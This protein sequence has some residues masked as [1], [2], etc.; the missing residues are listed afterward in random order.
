MEHLSDGM[1][2][3]IEESRE[4][5]LEDP[6]IT[7]FSQLLLDTE[8]V[9]LDSGM[10]SVPSNFTFNGWPMRNDQVFRRSLVVTRTVRGAASWNT[11][12]GLRDIVIS[13]AGM[14]PTRL[15][16]V[17]GGISVAQGILNAFRPVSTT[18]RGSARSE[19]RVDVIYDEIINRTYRMANSDALR[20]VRSLTSQQ[21]SIHQTRVNGLQFVVG[22][23]EYRFIEQIAQNYNPP[24]VSRTANFSS[25]WSRAF[26]NYVAGRIENERITIEIAGQNIRL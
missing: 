10:A 17:A 2:E 9:M 25:P 24:R 7:I 18:V 26:A 5:W 22:L 15:G 6:I 11:A 4:L 12:Q 23:Q 14:I 13:A 1:R 19:L 20:W 3:W 21:V 16:L 8:Q